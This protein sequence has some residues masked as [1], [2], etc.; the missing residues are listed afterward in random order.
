MPMPIPQLAYDTTTAPVTGQG[1]IYDETQVEEILAGP[2]KDI[3]Q[4][5]PG[6]DELEELLASVVSTEFEQGGLSE[7]LADHTVP[8]NWRVGEAIAEAF[9][10]GK[11]S[12]IFPW[13]TGRDLKNPNASPAGCD[14]TGFQ[15]VD[16]EELPHRF[17]FGEVKTSEHNQ[18]PPS[19]MTSLGNQ[20]HGLRDNRQVKNA[21]CRYLGHHAIRA[22]WEPMFKSATK[23]YLSSNST[24]VAVYG[25]LVRDIAPDASDISARVVSLAANCPAHTDI[26]MYALYLPVNAI[27]TL[28]ERAQAAMQE[29]S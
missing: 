3:L 5:T 22:D 1:L 4:D 25:V 16:D 26:E 14:L 28:S 8:N 15:P 21:L 9:V 13:P 10:A 6:T 27:S 24:D 11:G 19:V 20:L 12:C 17:A 18:S 23:R 2:V 29:A 7:L